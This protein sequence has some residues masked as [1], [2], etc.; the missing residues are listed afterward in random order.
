MPL[1]QQAQIEPED[2]AAAMEGEAVPA[3][4][5]PSQGLSGPLSIKHSWLREKKK[6]LKKKKHRNIII[7]AEEAFGKIQHIFMVKPSAN[8]KR[9]ELSQTDKRHLQKTYR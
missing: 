1:V 5:V 4:E 7:D 3:A 6:S 9:R 2:Q 8:W